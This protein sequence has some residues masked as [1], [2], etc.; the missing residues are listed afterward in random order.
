MKTIKMIMVALSL[1]LVS[2]GVWADAGTYN[3]AIAD[4]PSS[5]PSKGPL[6]LITDYIYIEDPI[7]LPAIGLERLID[8]CTMDGYGYEK[9]GICTDTFCNIKG[10]RTYVRTCCGGCRYY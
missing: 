2:A 3:V 4:D 9:R 10:Q 7:T 1:V 8:K 6:T 5:Q